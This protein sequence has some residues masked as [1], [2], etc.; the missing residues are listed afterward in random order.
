MPDPNTAGILSTENLTNSPYSQGQTPPANAPA[1][2]PTNAPAAPRSVAHG[3][4]R[5]ALA[6][7]TAMA[8]PDA[9]GKP[10]R[11]FGPIFGGVLSGAMTG[12]AAGA[13]R[14]PGQAGGGLA[15]MGRGYQAVQQRQQQQTETAK[16]DALRSFEMKQEDARTTLE[17]TRVAL[18]QN[19]SYVKV[20]D[21]EANLR[22]IN[23]SIDK[24]DWEFAQQKLGSMQRDADLI[25]EMQAKGAKPIPGV[26]QFHDPVAG[27]KWIADP[28]NAKKVMDFTNGK[29]SQFY[30]V[31]GTGDYALFEIDAQQEKDHTITGPNGEKF[32][33]YGTDF[34]AAH[35]QSQFNMQALDE[36]AKKVSIA[37]DR[38]EVGR[39][40]QETKDNSV[41][42]AA[43]LQD[44]QAQGNLRDEEA[45]KK[46]RD[47]SM[48]MLRISTA[49]LANPNA[50]LSDQDR[51]AL[52]NTVKGSLKALGML[53]MG[54][55]PV[56]I[57]RVRIVADAVEKARTDGIRDN[58][59]L[60]QIIQKS[61]L[62]PEEKIKVYRS[63]G[64]TTAE[65]VE[66]GEVWQSIIDLLGGKPATKAK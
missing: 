16:Q 3:I 41:K 34:D 53:G 48:E 23:Q 14:Q 57:D 18:A 5:G 64:V 39:F 55:A 30:R 42:L 47:T 43:E 45:A 20:K 12:L 1:P 11:G 29:V 22:L 56:N 37:K 54:S 26:P 9:N 46:G 32:T 17:R 49:I 58:Q 33:M 10:R 60:A 25:N 24:G 65:S 27:A 13:N 52:Q 8:G 6:A 36:K 59:A 40:V 19:E 38:A 21:G 15:A 66:W 61:T 4:L 63:T 31:A 28:E 51:A 44:M 35:A 50:Q 62:S 2:A 7:V